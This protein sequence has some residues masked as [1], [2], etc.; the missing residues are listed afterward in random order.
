LASPDEAREVGEIAACDA[1]AR[2]L[3]RGVDVRASRRLL[4]ALRRGTE[5]LVAANEHGRN[6]AEYRAFVDELYR[7]LDS[8]PT[9]AKLPLPPRRTLSMRW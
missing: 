2:L 9:S 7:L 1:E 5:Q 3:E 8:S 6:V 4:D